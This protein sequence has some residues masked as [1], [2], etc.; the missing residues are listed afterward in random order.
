MLSTCEA[1]EGAR[2]AEHLR[3]VGGHKS[4]LIRPRACPLKAL[5]AGGLRAS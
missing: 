1:W 5:S 2:L 4:T 3:G